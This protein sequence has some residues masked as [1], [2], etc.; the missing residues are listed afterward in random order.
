V[1]R[2]ETPRE[3]TNVD[4]LRAWQPRR[5]LLF[6]SNAFGCGS[7]GGQITA[8]RIKDGKRSLR[9]VVAGLHGPSSGAV[10]GNRVYF[11]EAKFRL[12]TERKDAAAVPR[13]VPFH[14]QS[15]E[16]PADE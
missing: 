3:L 5:L 11:T 13:G 9:I 14:L 4:A 12:L 1:A 15:Y 8:A 16:L 10:V 7:Y 2:I 6:E